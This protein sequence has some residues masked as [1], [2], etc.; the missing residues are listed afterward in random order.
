[1]V[2]ADAAV[3]GQEDIGAARGDGEE[4]QH[5]LRVLVDAAGRHGD[6]L[7]AHAGADADRQ[8]QRADDVG[9]VVGSGQLRRKERYDERTA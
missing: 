6:E 8:L 7:D 9:L 2:E 5:E 3:V 1:M 4:A